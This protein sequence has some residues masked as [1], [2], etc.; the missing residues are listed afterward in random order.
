MRPG[1]PLALVRRSVDYCLYSLYS[2]R[3]HQHRRGAGK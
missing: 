2:R 3:H 1:L